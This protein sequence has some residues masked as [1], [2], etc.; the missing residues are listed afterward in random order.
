M[1]VNS[2]IPG[3]ST[4]ET[5]LSPEVEHYPKALLRIMKRVRKRAESASL[6]Y[7]PEKQK[8]KEELLKI[9]RKLKKEKLQRSQ[10]K[11]FGNYQVKSKL[12]PEKS[13]KIYER[14]LRYI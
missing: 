2:P 8:N 7:I 3:T 1:S 5:T 9:S 12:F 4:S 14:L 11:V 10:F 13:K 6:T